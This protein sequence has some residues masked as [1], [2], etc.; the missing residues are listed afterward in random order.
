[1]SENISDLLITV[2]SHWQHGDI[3]IYQHHQSGTWLLVDQTT[4]GTSDS[5]RD[6]DEAIGYMSD[7]GLTMAGS[8]ADHVANVNGFETHVSI[9][10]R[11]SV[12][13]T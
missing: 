4:P 3:E 11:I 2:G 9:L 1:V 8:H 10:T 7:N 13:I 5:W 12:D 6:W